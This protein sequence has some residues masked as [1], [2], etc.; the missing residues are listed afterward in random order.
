MVLKKKTIT[1][2]LFLATGL[3]LMLYI[4]SCI[5]DVYTS[6]LLSEIRNECKMIDA[7]TSLHITEKDT[8]GLSTEGGVLFLYHD[9]TNIKKVVFEIYGEMGQKVNKYYFKQDKL[10]YFFER[11][12]HYNEPIYLQQNFSVESEQMNQLF[13]F[14][15]QL[16]QWIGEHDTKRESKIKPYEIVNYSKILLE[17]QFDDIE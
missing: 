11:V 4:F 17:L 3:S 10:I 8:F 14:N 9:E 13:F 5:D 12:L 7:D 16:V 6:N 15:D 1:R 2:V